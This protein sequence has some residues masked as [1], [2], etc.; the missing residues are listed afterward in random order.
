M[1]TPEKMIPKATLLRALHEIIDAAREPEKLLA[2]AGLT[3]A[4]G[5]PHA[6]ALGWIEAI[7][8]HALR[9]EPTQT[10]WLAPTAKVAP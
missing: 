4:N 9:A 5:A 7:A 8:C 10:G 2:E 3:V 6:Y 1:K